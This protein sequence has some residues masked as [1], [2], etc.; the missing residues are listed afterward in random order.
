MRAT[1]ALAAALLFVPGCPDHGDVDPPGDDDDTADDDTADDDTGGDDD[2]TGDDDSAGD[3]DTTPDGPGWAWGTIN[4]STDADASLVGEVP[5]DWAG[6]HLLAPGDVNGDG[7][8]DLVVGA[9]RSSEM[10]YRGGEVYFVMGREDGWGRQESLAGHPSVVGTVEN[11]ELAHTDRLGDLNGDGLADVAIDPGYQNSAPQC[12]QFAMLGKTTG[13][14]PSVPMDQADVHL[15]NLNADGSTDL[16]SC[17]DLGDMDGDGLDDWLLYGQVL[18]DG[19]AHVVSGAAITPTIEVPTDSAAWV[20]GGQSGWVGFSRVG[21]VNGDGID[22]LLGY[23]DWSTTRYLLLFGRAG[24]LPWDQEMVAAA[25]TI[26]VHES[27]DGFDMLQ[28]IGDVNGDGIDDLAASQTYPP[29]HPLSGLFLFFGRASWPASLSSADAD[30]VIGAGYPI[31]PGQRVGDVNDDGIDD[32]AYIG[33]GAAPD[34]AT[35]TY[36]VFGTPAWPTEIPHGSADVHI[37]PEPYLEQ[38]APYTFRDHHRGDLDGDGIEDLFLFHTG[39]YGGVV[40]AGVIAVFTGRPT[41]PGHLLTSEADVRFAG[42]QVYQDMGHV[43][44]SLV[45]DFNGDGI[46]DLATASPRHP[47][48]TEEGETFV[49]YGQPRL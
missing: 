4:T 26:L 33:P 42:D 45:D 49:F 24:G 32:L 22:D 28:W 7:I 6:C 27:G 46:D 37:E 15:I 8:H 12:G 44:W 43:D 14:A 19:E 5:D 10:A 40:D 39:D 2:A 16:R 13:W 36:L 41:W 48:G 30:V 20:Y 31:H 9:F 17:S 21:D 35:D 34:D 11:V 25:D 38:V 29:N 1:L 18:F 47:L 23:W 3:D